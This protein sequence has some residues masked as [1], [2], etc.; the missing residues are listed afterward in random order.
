MGL[1]RLVEPLT[2]YTESLRNLFFVGLIFHDF[3]RFRAITQRLRV[4]FVS[5][6]G[7]PNVVF[8]DPSVLV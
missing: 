8:P 3:L 5:L 2:K 4:G 1:I 6:D 7:L